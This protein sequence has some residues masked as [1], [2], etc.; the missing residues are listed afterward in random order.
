VYVARHN[1][2]N[3]SD[4]Q[5]I[6]VDAYTD[7]V[8][9]AHPPFTADI[10]KDKTGR[11]Q[12]LV[13]KVALDVE[14]RGLANEDLPPA[15]APVIPRVRRSTF[16][17]DAVQHLDIVSCWKGLSKSQVLELATWEHLFKE[18]LAS[19]LKQCLEQDFAERLGGYLGDYPFQSILQLE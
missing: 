10:P 3:T 19:Q 5:E 9:H 14:L 18:C 11:L 7:A 6:H 13:R 12:D 4:R 16:T 2:A 17:E 15:Y 8:G 1:Y